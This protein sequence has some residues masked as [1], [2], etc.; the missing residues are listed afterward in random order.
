MINLGAT[1]RS[2]ILGGPMCVFINSDNKY[3]SD[4][5]GNVSAVKGTE[6]SRRDDAMA[7][8]NRKQESQAIKAMKQC[9]CAL[10]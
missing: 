1:K 10:R 6:N 9:G 2:G 4:N 3:N 7:K 5:K 8:K